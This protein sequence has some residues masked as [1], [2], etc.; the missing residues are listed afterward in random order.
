MLETLEKVDTVVVDKTGTL[1]EGRPKL[2]ECIPVPPFSEEEVVRFAAS[3][4][5]NSEHPLAHAIVQGAKERSVTVSTVSMFDSITGGGVHGTVENRNVFIGKRSLLA[6]MSV[7][8]LAA[9]DDRA[10]ELQQ[11]GRTVMYVAVDDRFAGLVAVSD[12]TKGST[13]EAVQALHELGLRIIMLTGDNEKTA[14]VVA[15]KLGID[16]FHAGV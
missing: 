13:M 9:L 3:V 4:E 11:Q 10:D 15:E 12:P 1:T 2:T 7:Q 8:N 5:Q 16:E 6:D 14:K